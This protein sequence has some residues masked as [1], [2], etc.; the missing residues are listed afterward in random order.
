MT[1]Q[2]RLASITIMG[3]SATTNDR[4]EP[5][6]HSQLVLCALDLKRM[7]QLE[8]HSAKGLL[9]TRRQLKLFAKDVKSVF[10]A[11]RRKALELE[12]AYVDTVMRLTRAS[13][14]KD[15]ETGAHLDRLGHY[16][17]TIGLHLGLDSGYSELMEKAAPMHDVGK[18][19]IPDAI[20]RKKGPLDPDEWVVIK[21]HPGIGASLLMGSVSPL[22]TMAEEI[23]LTHH[24]RHDGTGYPRGLSGAGIPVCGRI[25]M[26]ADQYDALRSKRH[27]KPPFSHDRTSDIILNGDGRTLPEHFHPDV[28]DAFRDLRGTFDSIYADIV[29]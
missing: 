4:T 7:K 9:D 3:A 16:S 8:C 27:Y 11:E 13:Q 24:E 2:P 23:A 19:G 6:V 5:D 22:L 15:E 10:D 28:L 21:K 29:D 18:I 25:V 20:L 26:L 17:K 14:F 12:R 1:T